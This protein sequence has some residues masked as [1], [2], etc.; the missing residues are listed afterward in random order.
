MERVRGGSQ[1]VAYALGAGVA[2]AFTGEDGQ[3]VDGVE[4][5]LR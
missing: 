1:A 4:F 5:E 2:S 3:S